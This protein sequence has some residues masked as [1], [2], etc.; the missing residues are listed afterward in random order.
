MASNLRIRCAAGMPHRSHIQ[1]GAG[2]GDGGPL[3]RGATW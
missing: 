2:A 3:T 1:G